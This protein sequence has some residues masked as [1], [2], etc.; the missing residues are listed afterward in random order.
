MTELERIARLE[1]WKIGVDG[2]LG[3]IHDEVKAMRREQGYINRFLAGLVAI[4]AAIGVA[5]KAV[6]DKFS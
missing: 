4:G 3:D 5:L 2:K 6:W 1:Q